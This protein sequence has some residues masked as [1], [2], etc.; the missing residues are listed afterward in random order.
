M[1]KVFVFYRLGILYTDA[2]Y[3]PDSSSLRD[4]A[5]AT[6]RAAVFFALFMVD[7]KDPRMPVPSTQNLIAAFAGAPRA[8]TGS[9]HRGT[10]SYSRDN[11]FMPSP[12]R[13]LSRNSF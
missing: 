1:S 2:S 11:R 5:K 12:S 13:T 7:T 3:S 4:I 6:T 9:R 8:R 10:D